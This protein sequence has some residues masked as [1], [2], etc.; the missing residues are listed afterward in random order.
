MAGVI[1]DVVRKLEQRRD[2]LQELIDEHRQIVAALEAIRPHRGDAHK[3][4]GRSE[5]RK[6]R[7][8]TRSRRKYARRGQRGEQILAILRE[9]PKAKARQIAER[10]GTTPQNVY[11]QLR[12]LEQN[13][14][15]R[16]SRR[17]YVVA[18]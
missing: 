1:D 17:G 2:Q 10:A 11:Q 7:A 9:D 12:R 5:T 16:R 3:S 8:T 6:R 13:G 15:I 14:A 4:R 18:G